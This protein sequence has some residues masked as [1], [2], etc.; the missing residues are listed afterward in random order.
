MAKFGKFNSRAKIDNESGL[1]TNSALSGGRFF[2]SRGVPNIQVKGMSFLERINLFHILLT[3]SRWKF[4]AIIFLYFTCLNLIFTCIYLSIGTNHLSGMIANTNAEK[5]EEA[6][7]FSAQTFTTVGYGRINPTGFL[8]SL[9]ASLEALTG[10]LAFALAAG[11]MYGRFAR[12]RAYIRYSKNAL[13]VPFRDGVAV[14]FR[15]VPFTRNFLVNVEVK[16]TAAMRVQDDGVLKTRFF[17]VTL[18]IAK[19]TT[20]SSNWT[21]VHMINEDSP[22]FGLNKEDIQNSQLE[23]LVFVQGFDESFSNIVISRASYTYNELIYGAKFVPMFHPNEDN[24][25]TILYLDKLDEYTIEKLP[26]DY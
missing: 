25:S 17:N 9:V 10:L 6:F 16:V 15:M 3:I 26:V 1:T 11:L 2:N 21:I 22:L 5:F 7:F 8:A 13:L 20:L 24:T 18:D 14:M 4:F 12:P 19:A 23:L